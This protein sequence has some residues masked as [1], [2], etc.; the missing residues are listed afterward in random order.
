MAS[1]VLDGSYLGII[2]PCKET[3]YI[4]ITMQ[5]QQL[6]DAPTQFFLAI[7]SEKV[8]ALPSTDHFPQNT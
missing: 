4:P 5:L 6:F 7:T 3:D 1:A 2:P 8:T